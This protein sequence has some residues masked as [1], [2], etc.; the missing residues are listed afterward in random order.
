MIFLLDVNVLIALVDTNHQ[1]NH[2][3]TEWFRSE[4]SA[5]WATCPITENALIRILSHPGYLNT[6]PAT[7]IGQRFAKLRDS[8]EHHFWPDDISLADSHIFNLAEITSKNG[9]DIYLL[10]LAKS[11]DGKLA[12]FDRRLSH[13]GVREGAEALH[14]IEA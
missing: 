3:A 6:A 10:G 12:T 13:H 5:G 8:G 1:H 7:D 14:I 2:P 9:T 11:K 4:A